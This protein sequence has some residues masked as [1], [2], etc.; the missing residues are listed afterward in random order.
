MIKSHVCL[1]SRISNFK[2]FEK[3]RKVEA[4]HN[5]MHDSKGYQTFLF[6]VKLSIK[7]ALLLLG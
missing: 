4:V 2:L 1:D 7:V 6:L 3:R 5:E